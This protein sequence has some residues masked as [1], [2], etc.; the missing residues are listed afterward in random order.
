[1]PILA[2]SLSVLISKF[3]QSYHTPACPVNSETF[4]PQMPQTGSE[5]EFLK[6][7]WVPYMELDTQQSQDVQKTF[8]KNFDEIISTAKQNNI[9]TL[10]V[11]TRCYGDSLYN[12]KIFPLSHIFT[13]T[14]GDHINFDPLEYMI[15]TAHQNNLKIHAWINPLRISS[16]S[17]PQK[18]CETNPCK[19]KIYK[20]KLIYHKNGIIYN[21]GYAEVRQLICEGVKEI[22]DNYDIDGVHFDDYFYPEIQDMTSSDTAY[23]EYTKSGSNAKNQ[24][25][26]RIENINLLIKD[27]SSTIKSKKPHVQFGISPP[28]NINNCKKVGID[29]NCWLKEKYID[30]ICP[31]LYWSLECPE[32]PFE[33]ILNEWKEVKNIFNTKMYIG[34]ALYKIGTESDCGTWQND[35]NILCKECD[36]IYQKNMDGVILY[37]SKNLR[38]S[39]NTQEISALTQKLKSLPQ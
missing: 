35:K 22:M 34:L 29:F 3:I 1:M 25:E 23:E 36:L 38:Q 14:Q 4:S 7:L 21:P 11:H 32:M 33:N 24:C 26:W 5:N 2:I 20:N 16:N 37:S 17:T 31:Q 12:S 30:Y 15:Q 19:S 8:K 6:G 18:I 10:I 28:G 13:G 27:V 9:N 39:A